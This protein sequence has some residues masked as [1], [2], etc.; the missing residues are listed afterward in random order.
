MN[1]LAVTALAERHASACAHADTQEPPGRI[2]LHDDRLS[3]GNQSPV[4]NKPQTFRI[5]IP[6]ACSNDRGSSLLSAEGMDCP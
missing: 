1:I 4:R 6:K 2:V 3:A 5:P